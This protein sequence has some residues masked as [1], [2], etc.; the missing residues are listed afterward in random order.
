[1]ESQ[2]TLPSVGCVVD[3]SFTTEQKVSPGA[4]VT[5]FGAGMGPNQGVG[6]QLVSGLVPT[7]LGGTQ[8][9]VNGEPAP[10]LYSSYGQL[11]LIMPYSLAAGSAATIQVVSNGTPLNQ[12]SNVVVLAQAVSIFVVNGDGSAAAA[13]NEDYT[14]NSPQHPARPGSAVMLFGTGGGQTNPLSVAGAVTPLELRPLVSVP[15]VSLLYTPVVGGG[16]GPTFLNVEYAGA[17]PA[18]LSG[19]TQINVRLPDVIP[20]GY[21]P[22]ILPLDVTEGGVPFFSK[23]VTISVSSN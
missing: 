7:S 6:Y 16:P 14:V 2:P 10:I 12:L 19:V 1:V 20:S 3:T 15:L 5:L 22:G 23:T 8:V 13:L 17:A 18:Q 4:I 9:L 21:P 11:N